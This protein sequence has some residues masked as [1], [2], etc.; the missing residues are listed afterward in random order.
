MIRMNTT[1]LG[2]NQMMGGKKEPSK[3]NLFVKEEYKK[4]KAAHPT[5]KGTEIFKLVAQKWR[6]S[7]K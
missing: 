5:K 6:E 1:P 7:K 4:M 2:F 3:Y